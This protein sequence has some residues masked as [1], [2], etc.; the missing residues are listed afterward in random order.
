[1]N[2]SVLDEGCD[3]REDARML[4]NMNE[5]V[6]A[7]ARLCAKPEMAAALGP[8]KCPPPPPPAKSEEVKP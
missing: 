8:V 5:K 7:V 2:G 3:T 6:A 1:V 4:F